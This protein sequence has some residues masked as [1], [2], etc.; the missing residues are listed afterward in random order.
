MARQCQRVQNKN[1]IVDSF[2]CFTLFNVA[3]VAPNKN[4]LTINSV[5]PN[6]TGLDACISVR[7]CHEKARIHTITP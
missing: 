3:M 6:Q 1:K 5:M 4:R 2:L 7:V